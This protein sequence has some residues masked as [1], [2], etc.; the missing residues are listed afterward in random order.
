MFQIIGNH[1]RKSGKFELG[2]RFYTPGTCNKMLT[3]KKQKIGGSY[4][5]RRLVDPL[6]H[7]ELNVFP[8]IEQYFTLMTCKI[9]LEH[10]CH[11]ILSCDLV[12]TFKF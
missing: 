2:G 5:P 12:F 11:G 1:K 3:R 10:L 6:T 9:L 4:K 8:Q 7:Q